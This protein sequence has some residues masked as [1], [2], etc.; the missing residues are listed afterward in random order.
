[1]RILLFLVF[2]IKRIAKS[3]SI[4]FKIIA[5][6]TGL[7]ESQVFNNEITSTKVGEPQRFAIN[8]TVPKK[9]INITIYRVANSVWPSG[10]F[11]KGFTN[12]I[13][14]A[15]TLYLFVQF[16]IIDKKLLQLL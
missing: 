6:K 5:C 7:A 4:S 13:A 9:L 3:N 2:F 10:L 14:K 1:M 12:N 11:L 8:G 16:K 15:P